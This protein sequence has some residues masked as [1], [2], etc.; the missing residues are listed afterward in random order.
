MAELTDFLRNLQISEED[1][2]NIKKVSVIVKNYGFEI[3]DK[4]VNVLS[5]D[6]KVLGILNKNKLSTQRAKELW[7]FWLNMLF[8]AEINEEFH[9][10]IAKIGHTHVDAGVDEVIVVETTALFTNAT[11]SKIIEMKVPDYEKIIPSVIKVFSLSLTIMLDSYRNELIES[12]LEFTGMKRELF[13][14]EIEIQR[15]KRKS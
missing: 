2:E 7:Y 11:I 5:Q 10:K 4:V 1:T 3:I 14:K 13:E 8:S 15:R 12:F 9:N 6:K